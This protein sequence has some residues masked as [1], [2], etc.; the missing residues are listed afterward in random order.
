[1]IFSITL[2]YLHTQDEMKHHSDNHKKWLIE[3]ISSGKII[4]AGPLINGTGGYI[5]AKGTSV[6]EMIQELSKDPFV[7][8]GLVE[9]DIKAV[10]PAICAEVFAH[11]WGEESKAIKSG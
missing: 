7:S 6:D 11:Q 4:F 2:H 10:S 1:M 5:L 3:N 9:V 8:F